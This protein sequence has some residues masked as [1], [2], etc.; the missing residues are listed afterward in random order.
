M[1]KS[2]FKKIKL[3]KR[4]FNE[5][6]VTKV[7][8]YWFNVCTNCPKHTWF[9]R[10]LPEEEAAAEEAVRTAV[11]QEAVLQDLEKT[12][13]LDQTVNKFRKT[14]ATVSTQELGCLIVFLKSHSP[15]HTY[16]YD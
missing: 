14:I 16:V 1:G 4:H 15:S 13:L 8:N 7:P 6:P 12:S 11:I 3:K 10:N 9:L 2:G 5:R